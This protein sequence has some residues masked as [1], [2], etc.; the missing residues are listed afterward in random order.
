MA[1]PRVVR[2]E[3]ET[4]LYDYGRSEIPAPRA[5]ERLDED[6]DGGLR[7][8]ELELLSRLRATLHAAGP[9]E[10]STEPPPTSLDELFGEAV[11]RPGELDRAP[12]PPLIVGPV[13][14]FRRLDLDD[15]GGIEVDDLRGLLS[16]LQMTPR[17]PAIHATIDLDEDGRID[18]DELALALG[19]R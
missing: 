16:P 3:L 4:L 7:E 13:S 9:A 17:L 14:I 2:Y 11:P 19:A 10:P 5:F 15:D 18:P 12:Q 8:G 1:P 6:A